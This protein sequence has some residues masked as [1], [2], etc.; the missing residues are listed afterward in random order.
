MLGSESDKIILRN[1]LTSIKV[2]KINTKD[3]KLDEIGIRD[4]FS[5]LKDKFENPVRST[6]RRTRSPKGET[7]KSQISN[8]STKNGLIK[9]KSSSQSSK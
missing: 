1:K 7:I 5:M 8:K 4:K 6:S 2:N 3:I 9:S